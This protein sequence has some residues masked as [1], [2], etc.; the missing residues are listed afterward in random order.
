MMFTCL[1]LAGNLWLVTPNEAVN[2]TTADTILADSNLLYVDK[3]PV[4]LGPFT[5]LAKV[6]ADCN[7]QAESTLE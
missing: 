4:Y 2:L 5:S 3:Q 7:T 6:L 1:F